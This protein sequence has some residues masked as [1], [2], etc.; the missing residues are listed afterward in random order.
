[1]SAAM[2]PLV[3]VGCA[4]YNGEA[5]LARAL[6]PV[7]G[8]D[9]PNLEILISDDCSTDSSPEIYERFARGDSRIRVLRNK[10]NIGVTENL[11]RLA[12]EAAAQAGRPDIAVVFVMMIQDGPKVK[13]LSQEFWERFRNGLIFWIRT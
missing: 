3:T 13:N 7:V 11:N 12:R 2:G 6:A 4:V 8:Q 10:R 5:T 1:M 9:Y